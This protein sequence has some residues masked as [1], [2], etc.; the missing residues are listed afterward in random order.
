MDHRAEKWRHH[1][2]DDSPHRP[3]GD[4][5]R[6]HVGSH[7]GEHAYCIETHEKGEPSGIAE[8]PR[9]SSGDHRPGDETKSEYG[10]HPA[11][12]FQAGA[13]DVPIEQR[14]E[15][16]EGSEEQPDRSAE[17]DVEPEPT[18]AIGIGKAL[19]HLREASFLSFSC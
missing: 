14:L 16:A 8:P 15:R 4:H 3:G 1:T 7:I 12:R 2:D 19:F 5:H 17:P 13:Q 18:M 10:I 6:E 11:E 9:Q